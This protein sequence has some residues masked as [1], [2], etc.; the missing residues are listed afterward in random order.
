MT[1]AFDEPRAYVTTHT[2]RL[3]ER[4]IA[5]PIADLAWIALIDALDDAKRL[6][7][8]DWKTDTAELVAAI[9]TLHRGFK[10][11]RL[12]E[13]EEDDLSTWELLEIAGAALR[14]KDVQL[15]QLDMGSDSYCLVAVPIARAP[16][17]KRLAK[18]GGYGSAQLFGGRL[19]A[20]TKERIAMEKRRQ[21]TAATAAAV[22]QP[23]VTYARG[24]EA[25]SILVG[26]TWVRIGHEDSRVRRSFEH[27]FADAR[28]AGLARKLIVEWKA[29]GFA[30]L[31]AAQ[32]EARWKQPGR[33]FVPWIGP[34]PA[35]GAYFI[36][37]KVVQCLVT[38]DDDAV[39]T[40]GQ[41]GKSFG[42]TEHHFHGDSNSRRGAVAFASWPA[43]WKRIDRAAVL[44]KYKK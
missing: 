8:I 15:A 22:P 1:Q 31:T 11:R 14:K 30:A 38:R 27:T 20:A 4:G 18:Q 7:E 37:G 24:D 40:S 3:A 23:W 28:A 41:I 29:T 21:K 13:D 39:T 2:K 5:K 35:D 32:A 34:F 6:V 10:L 44:A 26:E 33:A 12:T 9:Q 36:S 19:A 43:V 16:D 25:W 17:L 42:E